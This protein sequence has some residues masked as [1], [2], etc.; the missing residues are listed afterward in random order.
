M[1]TFA[2]KIYQSQV[3][4]SV[5]AYFK[6]C[7]ELIANHRIPAAEIV[8]A[9]GEEKGL[10][11]IEADYKGGIA[12]PACPVKFV[13]TQKALAEGW[14]CGHVRGRRCGDC[15][16]GRSQPHHRHRVFPDARRTGRA[17]PRAAARAARA[18]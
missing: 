10:E 15:G 18:G 8:V 2:P 7:H 1:T 11:Q 6:A 9:T 12:D 5:E 14:D 17:L 4:E 13:I 3:L 16:G